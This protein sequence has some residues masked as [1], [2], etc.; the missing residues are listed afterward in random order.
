MNKKNFN[1]LMRAISTNGILD[2]D[3]IALLNNETKTSAVYHIVRNRGPVVKDLIPADFDL[4]WLH[5]MGYLYETKGKLF[6]FVHTAEHKI[7]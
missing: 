5:S 4:S 7:K 6:A 3:K 1:A 2:L